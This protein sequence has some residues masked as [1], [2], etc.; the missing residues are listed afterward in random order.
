MRQTE[1]YIENQ[2]NKFT[3]RKTGRQK[4]K[5]KFAYDTKNIFKKN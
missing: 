4:D 1:K 2:T 5:E 3:N